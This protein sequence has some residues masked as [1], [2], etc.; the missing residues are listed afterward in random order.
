MLRHL[1]AKG[2]ALVDFEIIGL[3]WQFAPHNPNL[4]IELLKMLAARGDE[5][6]LRYVAMALTW[7]DDTPDGWAVKF[8]NPEDYLDIL[9]NFE[10]LP[11]LDDHVQ[12][13]LE[14]LGHMDPIQVVDFIEQRIGNTA[15]R[16]ARDDQYDPIPFELSHAFESIRT[17]SAY[18]DVLRRVRDWMLHEDVW[19]RDEAPRVLKALAGSLHPSLYRVLMT[20]VESDDIRKLKEVARLLH[21]FNVGSP[22]YDL[23]REIICRTDDELILDSIAAAIDLTPEEGVRGGLSHFHRQRLEE[24]SPWLQDESFRV[25]RFAE[26]MRQ[27]LQS[28][29]EREQASEEFERRQW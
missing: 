7:P 23:C 27:S 24:I 18:I 13:C 17:S 26:R 10:R 3:I 28:Q 5:S 19:F 6:I 2:A 1:T 15:E 14:G 16:H 22:F 25:R 20:W 11:S 12:R 4:A 21:E 9:H 29:L 8:A